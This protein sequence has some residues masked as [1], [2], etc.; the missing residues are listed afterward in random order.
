MK[1]KETQRIVEY[2]KRNLGK[3]IIYC[4]N[5]KNDTNHKIE[6][7][8]N[9]FR[10]I[11]EGKRNKFRD[12]L[13]QVYRC[14]GCDSI[15]F[16]KSGLPSSNYRDFD[17]KGNSL[18][19]RENKFIP[20]NYDQ[21]LTF[22]YDAPDVPVNIRKVYRKTIKMYNEDNLTLCGVGIRTIIE[23][24]CKVE[25][26]TDDRLNIK[27]EKLFDKG[28]ITEELRQGL[29]QCRLLGNVSAHQLKS[30]NNKEILIAI[31]L[32]EILLELMYLLPKRIGKIKKITI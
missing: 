9:I 6:W 4:N 30:L 8:M 18:V 14:L 13:Y 27:I 11:G 20:E 22:R 26:I 16:L 17:E 1:E 15:T 2:S 3:E 12:D 23:E 21:L 19:K 24:V 31:Q 28:K 7:A 32:V 29:H 5:C 25:G 10:E